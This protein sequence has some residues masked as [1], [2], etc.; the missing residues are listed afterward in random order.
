MNTFFSFSFS[1]FFWI[2]FHNL[3]FCRK[4]L[5]RGRLKLKRKV[6][7]LFRLNMTETFRLNIVVS[8]CFSF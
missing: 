3:R 5:S 4:L 2:R 8:C 1:L 7:S 6:G